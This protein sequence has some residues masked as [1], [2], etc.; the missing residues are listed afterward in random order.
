[1]RYCF[2][3]GLFF[4]GLAVSAQDGSWSCYGQNAGGSRY[5]ALRQINSRNVAQLKVAWTCRTGELAKYEG[6]YALEKAAFETTP[7]L[8]GRTLYL[9]TPS[10]RVIAVDA[11]TGQ[12]RWV[13]DPNVNLHA[14]HSEISNRGVAYWSGGR[15]FIGTIDGRLIALDAATGRPAASFGKDGIVDLRAGVGED[16]AET[17]PPV[18]TGDLVIVG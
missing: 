5:S 18:V 12:Q 3:L 10:D 7:I 8:I 17:S 15:V 13:Y 16:V 1:M 6:T 4:W 11:A 14:D 2:F 9:S